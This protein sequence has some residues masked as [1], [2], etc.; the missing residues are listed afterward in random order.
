VGDTARR[1]D[2]APALLV[3]RTQVEVVLEEL[4]EEL[5]PVVIEL[6]LEIGVGEARSLAPRQEGDQPFV[7]DR[8]GREGVVVRRVS[9][10][11]AT[12]A[13]SPAFA[14]CSRRVLSLR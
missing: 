14:S 1:D 6:R 8:R 7:E 12:S 9:A 5:A 13:L 3:P 4:T 10:R 2:I 11:L